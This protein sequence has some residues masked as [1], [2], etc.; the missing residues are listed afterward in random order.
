MLQ[1]D[2]KKLFDLLSKYPTKEVM[3]NLVKMSFTLADDL[4]DQGSK[5]QAQ[6]L[7]KF[8]VS[9]EELISGRPYLI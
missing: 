1:R 4:S 2:Q 8:A 5:E 6:E 9:L 3:N 7:L